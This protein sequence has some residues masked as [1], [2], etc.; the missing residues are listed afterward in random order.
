MLLAYADDIDIIG[1]NLQEVTPLLSR[2]EKESAKFGLAVNEDKT[3][4]IILTDKT[5]TGL[6]QRVNVDNRYNFEAVDE[7]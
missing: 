5:Y 3:K 1:R 2:I 7:N 6:D 4:I